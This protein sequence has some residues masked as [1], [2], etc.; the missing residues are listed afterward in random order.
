MPQSLANILVH[1]VFSTKNRVPLILAEIEP[2][3]HPYVASICRE[4]R[5]PAHQIGS[6]DDHVHIVCSLGRTMAVATLLEEIKKSTSKW[7]KTKGNQYAQFSWQAGYGA[8][9]IGQSQLDAVKHYIAGQR[10]HHHR[11]TFQEE[12][13]D[14]LAKYQVPYDE[15]YVWD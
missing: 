4:C 15:R 5:S 10:E 2:E 1:I 11:R 6:T 8:F 7:M 12:F 14:F 13:R 3:L 9:S